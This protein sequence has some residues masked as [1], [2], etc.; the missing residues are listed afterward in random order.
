MEK[1][2]KRAKISVDIEINEKYVLNQKILEDEIISIL[3]KKQ[4]TLS[5]FNKVV[6]KVR[7]VYSNEATIGFIGKSIHIGNQ[8]RHHPQ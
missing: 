1:G 4:C 7:D 5:Q 2:N 8:N 3:M 6:D